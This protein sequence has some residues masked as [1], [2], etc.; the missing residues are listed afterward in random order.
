MVRSFLVELILDEESS[1]RCSHLVLGVW[2]IWFSK[3][4]QTNEKST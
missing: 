3:K 4:K 2:I 1:I